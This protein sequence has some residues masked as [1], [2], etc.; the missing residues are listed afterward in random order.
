MG[1][2]ESLFSGCLEKSRINLVCWE[3]GRHYRE[4]CSPT[5][6]IRDFNVKKSVC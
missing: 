5:G 4:R 2:K 3:V 6:K 1:R